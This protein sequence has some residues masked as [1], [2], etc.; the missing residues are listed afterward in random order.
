M[1]T[2]EIGNNLGQAIVV[3]GVAWAICWAIVRHRR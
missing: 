1:W 3:V 2:V